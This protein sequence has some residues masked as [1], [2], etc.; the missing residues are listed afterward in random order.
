MKKIEWISHFF[1]F[2]QMLFLTPQIMFSSIH[3]RSRTGGGWYCPPT[4]LFTHLVTHWYTVIFFIPRWQQQ[5]QLIIHWPR[6]GDSIAWDHRVINICPLD[7]DSYDIRTLST[8]CSFVYIVYHLKSTVRVHYRP[9]AHSC[10]SAAAV[11]RRSLCVHNLGSEYIVDCSFHTVIIDQKIT[12][13]L[14]PGAFDISMTLNLR[15]GIWFPTKRMH[16]CQ[17]NISLIEMR[18]QWCLLGGMKHTLID[19]WS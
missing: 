1:I 8:L 9:L 6:D 5:R 2:I 16:E 11:T 14:W 10:A 7:G 12:L 13:V 19:N 15:Y 18:T 4:L 17:T 3:Y